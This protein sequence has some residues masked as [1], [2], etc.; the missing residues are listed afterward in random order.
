MRICAVVGQR[1][2]TLASQFWIGSSV[3]IS[4]DVRETLINSA[5]N[6]HA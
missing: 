5:Q 6:L 1:I 2:A 3:Y 4:Q